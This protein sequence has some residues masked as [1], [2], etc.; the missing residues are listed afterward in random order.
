MGGRLL[1][2]WSRH[3]LIPNGQ[4]RLFRH[5]ASQKRVNRGFPAI[6]AVSGA[7][8]FGESGEIFGGLRR[9]RIGIDSPD[10]DMVSTGQSFAIIEVA[11][12][13]AYDNITPAG[14][15]AGEHSTGIEFWFTP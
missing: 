5:R 2:W 13:S 14:P 8:S 15:Q 3:L 4:F 11:G 1:P 7:V 9:A 6:P 12:F 10:L